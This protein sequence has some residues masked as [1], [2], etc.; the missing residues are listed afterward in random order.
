[1]LGRAIEPVLRRFMTCRPQRFDVA[2]ERIL[3]QGAIV[4]VDDATGK[5]VAIERVSRSLP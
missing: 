2:R 3:L 5:A 4:D 1:V